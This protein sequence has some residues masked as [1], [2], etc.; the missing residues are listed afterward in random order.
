ETVPGMMDASGAISGLGSI[1]SIPR[2]PSIGLSVQKSGRTTGL[3]TGT[4]QAVNAVVSVV[5]H[6]KCVPG[7]RFTV[8]FD[9]QVIIGG[10]SFSDSGDSGA[11]IVTGDACH[12][13]VGLLVAGGS[14]STSANGIGDVLSALQVGIV[15]N[16]AACGGAEFSSG[17]TISQERLLRAN[18]V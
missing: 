4:I 16:S 17:Q 8:L 5:Y 3:T 2:Q 6:R 15:G 13:P 12:Q 7:K 1:S 14:N 9:N 11:L 18:S 10:A